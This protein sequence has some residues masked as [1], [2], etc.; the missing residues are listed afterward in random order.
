MLKKLGLCG[1]ALFLVVGLVN[2][3]LAV[4]QVT[5][6]QRNQAITLG[7]QWLALQQDT[8]TATST[9]GSFGGTYYPVALTA[10]A[11]LKF[12]DHARQIG[13][14][15]FS[16]SYQYYDQVVDGW[17][18]LSTQMAPVTLLPQS[19][20]N[21]E[22]GNPAPNGYAIVF[23]SPQSTNETY[24]MGAVMMALQA[25]EA[26]NRIFPHSNSPTY[27]NGRTFCD[28][29]WE[30]VDWV[31]MA[32]IDWGDGEGGWVYAACDD[33]GIV[34][35][36]NSVSQWPVSGLLA[37]E[38][39]GIS[40]PTWVKTKL[41][42]WLSASGASPDG[43]F[44]YRTSPPNMC[45]T[46]CFSTTASGLLGL[47]YCGVQSTDPR[48]VQGDVYIDAAWNTSTVPSSNLGFL[49]AMYSVMKTATV[50]IPVQVLQF[51]S[52][53]WQSEYDLWLIANQVV[54][55]GSVDEGSWPELPLAGGANR[56][57]QTEFALLIL[58]RIAPRQP[59][60]AEGTCAAGAGDIIAYD[61]HTEDTD[62]GRIRIEECVRR[63]STLPYEDVYTYRLTNLS[64]LDDAGCGITSFELPNDLCLP[65]SSVGGYAVTAT[66]NTNWQVA[67]GPS[68]VTWSAPSGSDGI[69]PGEFGMFTF[70]VPGPTT[71]VAV[72]AEIQ[73]GCRHESRGVLTTGP[74]TPPGP[75]GPN[76]VYYDV[77]TSSVTYGQSVGEVMVEECVTRLDDH[78]GNLTDT[79][80][81]TVTNL[82]VSSGG[83]GL[84]VFAVPN[85]GFS[86][87]SQTNNL[88]WNNTAP[89]G[90]SVGWWLWTAPGSC[91]GQQGIQVGDSG[92]FSFSVAGP[93][94]DAGVLAQ[95]VVCDPQDAFPGLC[96]ETTGPTGPLPDLV[97]SIEAATCSC[98]E[99]GGGYQ[100]TVSLNVTVTNLGAAAVPAGT[101]VTVGATASGY[102]SASSSV[103]LTNDLASNS[104]IPVTV[105]GTFLCLTPPYC[106]CPPAPWIQ[107]VASVDIS[108]LAESNDSNNDSQPFEIC[109]KD[110]FTALWPNLSVGGHEDEQVASC[111]GG[112]C[113]ITTTWHVTNSGGG[114]AVPCDAY[115]TDVTNGVVYGPI[116]VPQLDPSESFLLIYPLAVLGC[117]C[118]L[119][120]RIDV[121]VNS[122]VT[123]PYDGDNTGTM[124]L[125]CQ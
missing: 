70:T 11:V 120:V 121:D 48:W 122:V 15:P 3:G 31:A 97:V 53:S 79:Y 14:D 26:P 18:Y 90:S 47:T 96:L 34:T 72:V 125:C 29:L 101:V 59:F 124:F 50:A 94:T 93:T 1:L 82:S 65:L 62:L 111:G 115:I 36:D 78:A 74:G 4:A 88:G 7:L 42:I 35:A 123:E 39:W 71:D 25:S 98:N 13:V 112:V 84:C 110:A 55:L 5:D 76:M 89:S 83:C 64:F 24:E 116:S 23:K 106:L 41:Q 8:T 104:S 100:C 66:G 103:T 81:Y 63:T 86:T 2:G 22:Q 44:Y 38:A 117:P 91:P 114:T 16:P 37:A 109:C 113:T 107:V 45:Y 68:E 33:Q 57:L 51:G 52:H 40:A 46:D 58:Q 28:I 32:Q 54:Q 105:V 43:R 118:P 67:S 80:T 30:C 69:M 20:H 95:A 102:G 73:T 60:C 119:E 61:G 85:A 92:T 56:V 99:V 49:Y 27:P 10:L 108:P 17:E 75:C 9:T 21:P 87:I 6:A 77:Q 12:E 19:G